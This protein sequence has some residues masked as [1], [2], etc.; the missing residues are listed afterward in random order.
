MLY[1][2]LFLHGRFYK[3]HFCHY[4][5]FRISP[6]C[7]TRMFTLHDF[8]LGC[9]HHAGTVF[10]LDNIRRTTATSEMSGWSGLWAGRFSPLPAPFP[11]L[12]RPPDSFSYIYFRYLF[13]THQGS[14]WAWPEW[15]W[16]CLRFGPVHRKVIKVIHLLLSLKLF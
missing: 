15:A 13:I 5:L 2:M 14:K 16:Y 12:D 11:L 10:V 1:M 8:H 4:F 7:L 9:F 6:W 3:C